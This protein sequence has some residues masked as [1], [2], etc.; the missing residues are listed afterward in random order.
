MGQVAKLEAL[1][2]SDFLRV[3]EHLRLKQKMRLVDAVAFV[4]AHDDYHMAR[5]GELVRKLGPGRPDA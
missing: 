5:V 2:E 3:S 1:K 4:C